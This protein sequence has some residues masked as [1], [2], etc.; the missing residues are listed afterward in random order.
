[1][2]AGYLSHPIYQINISAL[3][4][5]LEREPNLGKDPLVMTLPTK[6]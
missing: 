2:V 3:Y 4:I 6:I 5:K 1:M